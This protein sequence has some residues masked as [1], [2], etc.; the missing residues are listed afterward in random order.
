MSNAIMN[1]LTGM[2]QRPW[3]NGEDLPSAVEQPG[4]SLWMRFP[5]YPSSA[6]KALLAGGIAIPNS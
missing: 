6:A 5:D 3:V 4:G 1:Y 2:Y